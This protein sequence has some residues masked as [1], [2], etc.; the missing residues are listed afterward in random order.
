MIEYEAGFHKYQTSKEKFL[1]EILSQLRALSLDVYQHHYGPQ[2]SE[3]HR[4]T[5]QSRDKDDRGH[6]AT[7]QL[8]IGHHMLG[9][10]ADTLNQS[11]QLQK[12]TP[13]FRVHSLYMS[14]SSREI[15]RCYN[16]C[17]ESTL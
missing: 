16:C 3:I 14:M 17:Y 4:E 8:V 15:L 11:P 12:N 1:K 5:I 7:S 9:D 13:V 10:D 6:A 2:S